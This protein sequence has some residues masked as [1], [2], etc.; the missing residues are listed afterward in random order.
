M[1]LFI[2]PSIFLLWSLFWVKIKSVTF[3][4][5]KYNNIRSNCFVSTVAL[6]CSFYFTK[7]GADHRSG[8]HKKTLIDVCYTWVLK[9]ITAPIHSSKLLGHNCSS[10]VVLV[11]QKLVLSIVA[12]FCQNYLNIFHVFAILSTYHESNCYYWK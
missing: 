4:T 10:R 9:I 7:N 11:A 6:L 3:V 5:K 1:S 12:V 8:F 2:V